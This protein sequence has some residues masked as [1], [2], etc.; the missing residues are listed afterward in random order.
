MTL[1]CDGYG[2]DVSEKAVSGEQW[3][4]NGNGGLGTASFFLGI[5]AVVGYCVGPVAGLLAVVFGV[6][7]LIQARTRPISTRGLAV[8]G[9]V[10]GA[11]G[12]V[13]WTIVM[14]LL[15]SRG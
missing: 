9:T 14:L 13:G 10:M 15:Y 6:V 11:I 5:L 4:R 2:C 12:L 8:W 7:T 1:R 3:M